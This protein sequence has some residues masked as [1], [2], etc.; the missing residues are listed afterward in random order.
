M[1]KSTTN[2][3]K[4]HFTPRATLAAAWWKPTNGCA[5][6]TACSGPLGGTAALLD[7]LIHRAHV[8]EFTGESFRFR[9]RM[10]REVESE[11]QE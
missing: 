1:S 8:L 4:R 6:T 2:R 5:P 11:G 3:E 7:R 10:Q 9:Q